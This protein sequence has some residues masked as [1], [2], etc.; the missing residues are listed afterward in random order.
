MNESLVRKTQAL[1]WPRKVKP[2]EFMNPRAPLSTVSGLWTMFMVI[3]HL[4]AG[5]HPK[6]FV[7]VC[8][9]LLQLAIWCMKGP[10]P[11]LR[12]VFPRIRCLKT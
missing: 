10:I 4:L 5:M 6:Y 8:L 2:P 11:L 3:I 12:C 9:V 7:S 1:R